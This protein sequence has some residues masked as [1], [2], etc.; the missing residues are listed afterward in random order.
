LCRAL[1]FKPGMAA[2]LNGLI[3]VSGMQG[4]HERARALVEEGMALA[5]ASGDARSLADI[6]HY[7]AITA[8]LRGDYPAAQVFVEESL[9]WQ[10]SLE[11][12]RGVASALYGLGLVL[13]AQGQFG[14]AQPLFEASLATLQALDDKRSVTMCLAGLAEIA[15]S[16][17]DPVTARRLAEEALIILKEVGDR[18]FAAFSLDGLAAAIAAEGQAEQAVRFFAAATAMRDSIGA[19]LP[20]ARRLVQERYLPPARAELGEARFAQAWQAG[21]GLTL[22]GVIAVLKARQSPPAPQRGEVKAPSA[23]S[24]KGE[25]KGSSA[26]L[27]PREIEVL[28][29][30]AQGLTDAQ[31]AEKLV[32]SPRTVH[33]HLTSIY[34]KLGVNSRTAAVRYAVEQGLG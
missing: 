34:N 28:H 24:Q 27:T 14:P 6:L 12:R 32:I 22:E 4:D 30:V 26:G 10:R 9:A 25:T 29:L 19:A 13:I 3:F 18:W 11:D 8:W 31:V 16:R 15:L 17:D 21:Q 2:A 1:D 23:A 20:A 33:S 7:A 5:R